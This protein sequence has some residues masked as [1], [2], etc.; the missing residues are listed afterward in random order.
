VQRILEKRI[1]PLRE[2][3]VLSFPVEDLDQA[4]DELA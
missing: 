3:T 4:V 1:E 2:L